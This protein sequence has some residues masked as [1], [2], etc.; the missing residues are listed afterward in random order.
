[1]TDSAETQFLYLSHP[2]DRANRGT[3]DRQGRETGSEGV[4]LSGYLA[5]RGERWASK[6]APENECEEEYRLSSDASVHE[7]P[8]VVARTAESRCRPKWKAKGKD[9]SR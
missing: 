9:C 6:G 7:K 4:G 5:G 8:M 1:M 3:V 2:R